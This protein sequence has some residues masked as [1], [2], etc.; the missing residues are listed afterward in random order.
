V[1]ETAP[2][3]P[4]YDKAGLL[5]T[6]DGNQTMDDVTDDLLSAIGTE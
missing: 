4:F 3:I 6:V 5:K 1:A 2:L